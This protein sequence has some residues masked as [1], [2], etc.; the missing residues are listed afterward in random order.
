MVCIGVMITAVGAATTILVKAIDLA[1]LVSQD[2]KLYTLIN[3]GE[4]AETVNVSGKTT[5]I[6]VSFNCCTKLPLG[7][8]NK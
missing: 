3:F 6:V 4:D 1:K 5:A 2:D 7:A 8:S